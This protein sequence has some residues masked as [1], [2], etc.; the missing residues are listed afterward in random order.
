MCNQHPHYAEPVDPALPRSDV[1]LNLSR[2]ALVVI[3]PQIDFMS[4]AGPHWRVTHHRILL[5]HKGKETKAA[6]WL[7]EAS[8][9][10]QPVADGIL[11]RQRADRT[12]ADARAVD[13]RGRALPRHACARTAQG[14]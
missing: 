7:R 11:D 2:T 5:A 3:D 10:R 13:Q 8:I 4:P 1:K 14:R 6:Q 12:G 9:C